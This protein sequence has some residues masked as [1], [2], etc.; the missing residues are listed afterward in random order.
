MGLQSQMGLSDWTTIM[1]PSDPTIQ[2]CWVF[3]ECALHFPLF[4][5]FSLNEISFLPFL[6]S[7]NDCCCVFVVVYL[8]E[9]LVLKL[10]YLA[11]WYE[12]LTQW[13]RLWYWERLKAEWEEGDRGWDGW[14]ASPIQ[15]TSNLLK[16]SE[17]VR[18]REAWCAAVHGVTKRWTRLD[19]WTTDRWYWWNYLQGSR[20]D[21][22]IENRLVG[23]VGEEEGGMNWESSMETYTVLYVK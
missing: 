10:Q 16:L 20:R 18:A 14:M 21:T 22:D 7:P 6:P 4:L 8:L 12:Q 17:M 5:F 3:P 2:N 11:I 9:G 19:N 1:N 15:W 13:K 23:T